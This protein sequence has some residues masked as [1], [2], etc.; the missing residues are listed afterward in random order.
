MA[1][2]SSMRAFINSVI[3]AI[4]GINSVHNLARPLDRALRPYGVRVGLRAGD[5]FV[6]FLGADWQKTH[7]FYTAGERDRA[8]EDMARRHE[9]SRIG[10]RPSLKFEKVEN[11]SQSRGI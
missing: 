6:K 5:P 10:D 1:A 9:Y 11:L 4:M 3:V 7:W 8:L 2:K